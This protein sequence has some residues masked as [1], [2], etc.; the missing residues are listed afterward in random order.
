LRNISRF[1]VS[2]NLSGLFLS[3]KFQP[4]RPGRAESSP[5]PREGVCRLHYPDRILAGVKIMTIGE[6]RFTMHQGCPFVT[7]G[8]LGMISHIA[9]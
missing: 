6:D 9:R 8:F 5:E 1:T 2:T 3:S 7:F 4:S